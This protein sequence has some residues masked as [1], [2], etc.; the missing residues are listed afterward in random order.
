MFFVHNQPI[1]FHPATSLSNSPLES[2]LIDR[3]ASEMRGGVQSGLDPV[4]FALAA[5]NSV[6]RKSD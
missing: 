4:D 3:I 1:A 6:N 5:P 2:R